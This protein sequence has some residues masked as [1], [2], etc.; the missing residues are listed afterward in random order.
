MSQSLECGNR[1]LYHCVCNKEWFWQERRSSLP[2]ARG[3]RVQV[4]WLKTSTL[5]EIQVGGHPSYSPDLSPCDYAI[6]GPLEK[7]LRG[8]RFTSYDIK[9]YMQNWFTRQPW[10]FYE[11]ATHCLVLQW[12]KEQP[13]P[14]F[15]T[16][17]Y[18]FLFLGLWLVSFWMPAL[19]LRTPHDCSRKST[20]Y[21]GNDSKPSPKTNYWRSEINSNRQHDPADRHETFQENS[22]GKNHS[23]LW[24]IN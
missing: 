13:G 19:L 23:S 20:R 6:F 4:I 3:S 18:W 2:A 14:I 1:W 9:Q 17:R 24:E 5:A 16:Y 12:D 21:S 22:R 11:T 7:A 10:E 15:L 8:K